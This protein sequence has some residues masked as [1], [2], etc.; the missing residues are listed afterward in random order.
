MNGAVFRARGLPIEGGCRKYLGMAFQ[1]GADCVPCW[2]ASWGCA[3]FCDQHKSV[4]GSGLARE[5]GVSVDI[6]MSGP[7]LS[8]AGSLPQWLG[9]E[10]DI[11]LYTKPRGSEPARDGVGPACIK[12]RRY[13]LAPG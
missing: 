1:D 2:C 10:L 4:C 6:N 11:R 12:A 13:P 5:G 7:P 3:P 8:R 9:V